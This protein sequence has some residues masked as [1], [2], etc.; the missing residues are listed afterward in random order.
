MLCSQLIEGPQLHSPFP[1][2]LTWPQ[3]SANVGTSILVL[4]PSLVL[5]TALLCRRHPCT[6]A[7]TAPTTEPSRDRTLLYPGASYASPGLPFV[8]HTRQMSWQ[9]RLKNL[10]KSDNGL[11]FK[12]QL[13]V[14]AKSQICPQ[15]SYVPP[16]L[17]AQ[18][19]AAVARKCSRPP[20]SPGR[21]YFLLFHL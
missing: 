6:P 10:Y 5:C 19:A 9:Y 15:G 2:L 4:L 21:Q 13:P 8:L 1:A 16:L 3:I 7:P 18:F 12:A 11:Q 17:S 20:Q 14:S